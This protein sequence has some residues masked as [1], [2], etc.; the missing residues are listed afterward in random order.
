MELVTCGGDTT[1]SFN[2]TNLVYHLKT[3]YSDEFV[4]LLVIKKRRRVKEK[5]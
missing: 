1:K 3:K 5:L 2:T 4:W